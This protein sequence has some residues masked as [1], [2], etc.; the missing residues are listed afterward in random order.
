MGYRF[1]Y[2]S[3]L[4]TVG[5]AF[6]HADVLHAMPGRVRPIAWRHNFPCH[7]NFHVRRF[8][9]H[10][11]GNGCRYI[12]INPS[13]NFFSH[14][15]PTPPI[16]N[17]LKS[18]FSSNLAVMPDMRSG[19]SVAYIG[20]LDFYDDIFTLHNSYTLS[21]CYNLT[22]SPKETKIRSIRN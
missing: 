5:Q 6:D 7:R 14:G 8:T 4:V 3:E 12:Y 20:I 11:V 13:Q 15:N 21:R 10:R 16:Y 9:A 2:G 19:Y 22:T 18:I 1:W 17:R